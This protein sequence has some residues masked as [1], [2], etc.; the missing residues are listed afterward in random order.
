MQQIAVTVGQSLEVFE[1]NNGHWDNRSQT[2]PS[3]LETIAA[4]PQRPDRLFVGSF[5]DGL[6]RSTDAGE[7]FES[8]GT[9]TIS[10]AITH[11]TID[12]SN[13]DIL[14]CGTEPSRLYR[15]AD[16]GRTWEQVT[17]LTAVPSADQWSF[18]PRPDT[19]HVRWIEI[20]P[21]D[22]DRWYVGIEA[23]ALVVTTDGG[24]TWMDRPSGS[25]R[26]NHTLATHAAAPKRVYSA[27][28]D[29]YA[30]STDG[31]QT[32]E[33]ALDG[34]DH[35]YVWGLAVDA[36]DPEIRL[37]SAATSASQAHGHQHAESYLYRCRD[38]EPWERLTSE[39]LQTG[40]GIQRAVL[41]NGGSKG[42]FIGATNQG[43]F[44]SGDAGDSWERISEPCESSE[45]NRGPRAIAVV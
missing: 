31:G 23:G 32:W 30:E 7:N 44:V 6:F 33:E 36:V 10:G 13:P 22:P 11:V 35:R 42:S 15:S 1:R 2:F 37:V 25:R 14:L 4:H 40:P 19:H 5:S 39:T 45:E 16:G 3:Q 41:A 28:G 18:P 21:D 34:L 8:V 38:G 43:V 27:A 24:E 9:D 26:D 12:P 20:A 29:G 17:G